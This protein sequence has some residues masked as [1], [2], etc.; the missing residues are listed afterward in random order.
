MPLP[1]CR[2][3]ASKAQI[4]LIALRHDTS[5]H[6]IYNPCILAQEN[7]LTCCVA[8]VLQHGATCTSRQAR[9]ARLARH[10]LI[11]VDMSTLLFPEVVPEIDANPE[12]KRLIGFCV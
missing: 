7:I 6:A 3:H 8:L 10:V 12:H 11:G 5:R 1:E 4:P 9:Q 2:A